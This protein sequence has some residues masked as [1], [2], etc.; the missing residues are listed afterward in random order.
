ME[1]LKTVTHMTDEGKAKNSA[2]YGKLLAQLDEE[3]SLLQGDGSQTTAQLL[4]KARAQEEKTREEYKRQ[5][6][7][8]IELQ[9]KM[10]RDRRE[11]E[12]AR[13]KAEEDEKRR[14]KEEAEEAAIRELERKTKKYYTVGK[15]K[16]K[17]WTGIEYFGDFT[18]KGGAWVPE[19]YGEH[20]NNGE[21]IYDGEILNGKMHGVG[22]IK[23]MNDDTWKGIF[24][25][26]EPDG[27]G[28]YKF[29]DST[30][31]PRECI[32]RKSRRVCW[33][34]ELLPGTRIRLL[35]PRHCRNNTCTLICETSK[36]GRF[37]VKLDYGRFLTLDFRV[38][39][40]ELI[41][42]QPVTA[43]LD[44]FVHR[45]PLD[46]ESRFTFDPL[47]GTKL[48]TTTYEENFYHEV[49][50]KSNLTKKKEE[51]T[52]AERWQQQND[53]MRALLQA[54]VK[55]QQMKK[56]LEAAQETERQKK[57][58]AAEEAAAYERELEEKKAA[59]KAKR[60]AQEASLQ[61][62]KK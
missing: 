25:H 36:R 62:G 2:A 12:A 48:K 27:L 6:K 1:G 19:Y 38:E 41:K 32:Y 51:M 49:V 26:D 30:L 3:A 20:R 9:E 33:L 29:A 37:K 43:T 5:A 39:D 13:I 54:N 16:R 35:D 7:M 52:D 59:L 61:D 58:A 14:L 60:E 11:A 57:E 23:F 4:A 31:A 18:G 47:R 55:A 45:K 44:R 53:K 28:L 40:F 15:F 22:V 56:E 42:D 8:A 17:Q 10:E 34:D 21:V 24:K 50:L 46:I